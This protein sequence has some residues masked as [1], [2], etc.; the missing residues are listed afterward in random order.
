MPDVDGEAVPE[1]IAVNDGIG[2][3]SAEASEELA[4]KSVVADAV[5]D[6]ETPKEKWAE[7]DIVVSVDQGTGADVRPPS[8][9][10]RWRFR[11]C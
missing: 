8:T 11:S 7:F 3:G 4:A 1:K 6:R 9:G 2:K 10:S 5:A